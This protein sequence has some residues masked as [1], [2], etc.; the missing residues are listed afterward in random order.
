[1][2]TQAP[3]KTQED[4]ATRDTQE[5]ILAEAIR[6]LSTISN[7]ITKLISKRINTLKGL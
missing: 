2:S 7:D 1:M 5:A 6:A 4:K 3:L